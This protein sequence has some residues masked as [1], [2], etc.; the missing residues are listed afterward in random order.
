M[1]NGSPRF[2]VNYHWQVSHFAILPCHGRFECDLPLHSLPGKP[3]CEYLV[4][5][6]RNC[7]Q[8]GLGCR[9]QFTLEFCWAFLC[10]AP[11]CPRVCSW[12]ACGWLCHSRIRVAVT[13]RFLSS[14]RAGQVRTAC[15]L[16]CLQCALSLETRHRANSAIGY[17]TV[18]AALNTLRAT[19]VHW[20]A[21][22][23]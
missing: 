4:Q 14:S 7:L 1:F 11:G 15:H 21:L 10:V 2:S 23:V 18:F 8:I 22:Q 6:C 9:H 17:R 19:A 3:F 20:P 5:H 16:L 12:F 13:R